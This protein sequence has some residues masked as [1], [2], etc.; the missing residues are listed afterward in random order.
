TAFR[1]SSANPSRPVP[2][3]MPRSQ[4]AGYFAT[5]ARLP[6]GWWRPHRARGKSSSRFLSVCG[7]DGITVRWIASRQ[8]QKGFAVRLVAEILFPLLVGQ[9]PAQASTSHGDQVLSMARPDLDS[10]AVGQSCQ[11]PPIRAEHHAIDF[12]LVV[13]R[14]RDADDFL[15]P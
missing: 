14:A 10:V 13:R 1:E 7:A 12:E 4:L 2:L 11:I 3:S 6:V 15:A 5:T 8:I 9:I